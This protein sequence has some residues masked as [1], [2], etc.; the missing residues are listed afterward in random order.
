MRQEARRWVAIRLLRTHWPELAVCPCEIGMN[1]LPDRRSREGPFLR[2]PPGLHA[3]RPLP[4]PR[5]PPRPLFLVLPGSML[6]TQVVPR[7]A[8]MDSDREPPERLGKS[9]VRRRRALP[10]ILHRR[11]CTYEITSH[12]CDVRG[13]RVQGAGRHPVQHLA[14]VVREHVVDPLR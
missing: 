9:T 8:D 12:L 4:S 2:R 14:L 1:R 6:D 5:A 13:G 11:N 7:G 3:E 10:R